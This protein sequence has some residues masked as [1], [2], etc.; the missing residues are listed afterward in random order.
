MHHFGFIICK[1]ETWETLKVK[2][3]KKQDYKVV[4]FVPTKKDIPK[5]NFDFI[6]GLTKSIESLKATLFHD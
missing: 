5:A 6:L 3:Y 2:G 4:F 1:E